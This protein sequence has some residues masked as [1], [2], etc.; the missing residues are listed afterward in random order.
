[1]NYEN[2]LKKNT[3]K[4]KDK[5]EFEKNYLGLKEEDNREEFREETKL[6]QEEEVI[7]T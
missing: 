6:N 5:K 7:I 2:K 1:M 3:K 4:K